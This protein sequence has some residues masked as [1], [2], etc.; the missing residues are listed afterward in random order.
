MLR[1]PP[2]RDALDARRAGDA[3]EFGAVQ[4]SRFCEQQFAHD[5]LERAEPGDDVAAQ[6]L[7]DERDGGDGGGRADRRDGA[8]EHGAGADPERFGDQWFCCEGH[9]RHYRPG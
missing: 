5:V 1:H 4:L 9:A 8:R 2:Q 7:A 6:R 3:G